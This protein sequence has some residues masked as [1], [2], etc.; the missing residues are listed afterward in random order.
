MTFVRTLSISIV[1]Q[2]KVFLSDGNTIH[3]IE[4]EAKSVLSCQCVLD[5]RREQNVRRIKH[6]DT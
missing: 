3:S 2:K 6:Q 4:S 1:S 5:D